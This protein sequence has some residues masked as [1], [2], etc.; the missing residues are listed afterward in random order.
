MQQ[1]AVVAPECSQ[2]G[3]RHPSGVQCALRYMQHAGLKCFVLEGIA[4]S[5]VSG[6]W[7]TA[8]TS[9]TIFNLLQFL[10]LFLQL[11]LFLHFCFPPISFW[12]LFSFGFHRQNLA[13]FSF[14]SWGN[15]GALLW[16]ANY[17]WKGNSMQAPPSNR[18]GKDWLHPSTTPI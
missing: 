4:V 13:T 17:H 2:T 3:S 14:F 7:S 16:E 12:C 15:P 6:P 10:Q 18:V 11:Q 5:N 9:I 1:L 8:F